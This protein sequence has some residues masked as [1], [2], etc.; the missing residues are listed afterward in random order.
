MPSELILKNDN[1]EKA[2]EDVIPFSEDNN[3]LHDARLVTFKQ[4]YDFNNLFLN[5]SYLRKRV[6]ST[7]NH[8]D[9]VQKELDGLQAWKIDLEARYKQRNEDVE[10]HFEKNEQQFDEFENKMNNVIKEDT[11][12]FK[13]NAQY[14]NRLNEA[15]DLI[16]KELESMNN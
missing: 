9:S 4:L 8:L 14:L 16:N 15:I 3:V 7:E 11:Q 12:Q 13:A 10:V 1:H 6:K 5:K 2:P